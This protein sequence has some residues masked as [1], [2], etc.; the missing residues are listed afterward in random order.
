MSLALAG[1]PQENAV[2]GANATRHVRKRFAVVNAEPYAPPIYQ[3]SIAA[4]RT[5]LTGVRPTRL[6]RYQL[7]DREKRLSGHST[8]VRKQELHLGVAA[9]TRCGRGLCSPE[10]YANCMP[11]SLIRSSKQGVIA[12]PPPTPSPWL[13]L[14]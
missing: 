14:A 8:C 3:C 11:P 6:R 5:D 7:R 10:G 2:G 1:Q 4:H 12:S 13:A 9:S